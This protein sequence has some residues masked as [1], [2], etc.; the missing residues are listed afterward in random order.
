VIAV[1]IPIDIFE[2]D[3]ALNPIIGFAS[4]TKTIEFCAAVLAAGSF[5]A[6]AYSRGTKEF[7]PAG[8]GILLLAAGKIILQN[9]DALVLF[10]FAPVMLLGGM[11]LFYSNMRKVYMWL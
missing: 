4:M 6:G 11:F 10:I 8:F 3:T 7:I 5:L 2:F 1:Q 9:A